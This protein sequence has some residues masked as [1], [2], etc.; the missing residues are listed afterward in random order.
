MARSELL[1]SSKDRM[2]ARIAWNHADQNNY[3]EARRPGTRRIAMEIGSFD[4]EI[5]W[6]P[7]NSVI[8]A[9]FRARRQVRLSGGKRWQKGS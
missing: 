5:S 4:P 7:Y 1:F 3:E 8:L 9:F 2:P 6:F